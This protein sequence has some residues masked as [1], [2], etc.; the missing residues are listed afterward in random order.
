MRGVSILEYKT[1][2]EF[3]YKLETDNFYIGSFDVYLSQIKEIIKTNHKCDDNT[4]E[5]ILATMPPSF[6]GAIV[7]KKD[8]SLIGSIGMYSIDNQNDA[9][10][11]RFES[12]IVLSEEEKKEI[13]DEFYKYLEDS[14]NIHNICEYQYFDP[15][16]IVENKNKIVKTDIPIRSNYLILGVDRRKLEEFSLYYNIPRLFMEASICDNGKVVG[17]V[18]LSNLIWSNKRAN[19]NLFIDKE[20]EDTMDVEFISSIINEYMDYVHNNNIYNIS[21]SVSGS[22]QQML[23]IIGNSDMSFYAGI[24]YGATYNGNIETNYMFQHTPFMERDSGII[25]PENKILLSNEST[26]ML[27]DTVVMEDGYRLVSPK[28][29]ERENVDMSKVVKGHIEAMQNRDKFSIPLG[30]DKY[31]IQEGNGRYGM[32]KAL[33]NYSYV[34]LNSN[35]DYSGYVNILRTNASGKNAE[36][37]LGIKPGGQKS[38]LG[39]KL[40]NTFYD[41]MFNQGYASVT[42][43][44]FDFNVPSLKLHEKVAS[45]NGTRIESYYINGKL[46]DMHYFT[47]VNPNA[48][49][50]VR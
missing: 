13:Y 6:R 48:E 45:F 11:I 44:V 5:Q 7:S 29:F 32:S 36:I 1:S 33:A 22:N 34:L 25:I 2:N 42:S 15:M 23:D 39:T 50:K 8:M 19:L 35:N 41:E 43:S 37:E 17:I 31:F 27:R 47:K 14:L 12:N 46:W 28:V 24:P 4:A 21:T 40:I 18:G 3:I 26:G 49:H 30:E 9:A 16:N 10:S 20:Y 38:G